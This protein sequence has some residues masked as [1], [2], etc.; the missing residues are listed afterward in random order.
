MQ[1]TLLRLVF[2][3]FLSACFI[4]CRF[5]ANA[6]TVIKNDS[7]KIAIKPEYDSVSN[8]HRA[9]FGTDYR[10]LWATPVNIRVFH[11]NK[12]RGGLKILQPGG[13]MQTKSLRLKDSTG[14]E[15][16]LRTI[17]K[18]PER[19]LPPTLRASIA[20]DIVQDQISAENPFAAITIPPLAQALG[21]PHAHPE[22]VY[23]ADDPALGKYR[24]DYA[25]HVFLFEERE[26]LDVDK[27]DNTPKVQDKLQDDNDNRIDEK[28]VLKARLLDMLVGDWDRHEDQWRFE[29]L[30]DSVGIMYKPVPRD[31][32]QVYYFADG[33]LP[34]LVSRYLLMAK[35]QAYGDHIR[36]INRWN[37]NARYFDRYFLSALNE[38]DW[39]EQISYVQ[40]TLTDQ[41]ITDAL[42]KMPP[43]V[44]KISGAGIAA[45]LIARRNV[46]MKQALGYYRFLSKTVSV[47]TSDKREYFNITNEAGGKVNVTVNKLKKDGD[48]ERVIYQR[49][50]DPSVTNE[51]RL[52]GMGGKDVFAV[53]GAD[54]SP[55]TVRMIGGDGEDTFKVDSNITG[56]GNR[57]IYDRSDQKNNLPPPSQ[58]HLRT[59]VDTDANTYYKAS[60]KY[61]FLEPLLLASYNKDYG[62]QL[63]G[64]FVYEKQGFRV[65]PYAFRQALTVNY[66]FGANSLLLNYNA[67]FKQAVGNNDLVVN[68]LSKGP[69]YHSDFFGVGNDTRFVNAG[70]QKIEYYRNIYDYLNADVR[71]R[72]QYG[73]WSVSEGVVAQYYNGEGSDNITKYLNIYNQEHPEE[74]VFSTESYLGAATT[75]VLDTRDKGIEPHNGVL[76]TTSLTGMKQINSN[77]H[78]YGQ[79]TSEL[80]FYVNPGKDSILVFANR[81]GGG[82]TFGNAAYY[83]QLKLGGNLNLRGYYLWRFTGKSMAYDNFEVRVKLADVTSYLLPG[84]LGIIG[85]DDIGRVWASG[86]SSN[87]LHDGYGVGIYFLPGQ[88]IL[89]Q[90]VVGFSKEGAY[91]YITAGFRF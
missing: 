82:T 22:I 32:D 65:Y 59:S 85:F 37:L 31:R 47:S 43:N 88:L 9:F 16:V 15:W 61:N 77:E 86:Q 69:N 76:W 1:K 81:I 87:T 3:V 75:A 54:H 27:T 46:L 60:F 11:F 91:P 55:I 44:Y 90:A 30:K 49:T 28:L 83:N 50:F 80:S 2:A 14:Q 13:G 62:L 4:C 78:S 57:Y 63:I 29:R 66:G 36:S 51:I 56:K 8:L 24:K 19:I 73:K 52:Y 72:H 26:P 17:E 84:T 68:V 35:L 38:D 48:R 79:L 12:E 23:V 70:S 40:K 64:Q 33:A 89:I 21:V 6:Q 20:K 58:A 18:Y 39:K 41:V 25:N 71:L 74:H 42:K 34:W 53:H 5:L 7:I 67:I 45:K 10:S